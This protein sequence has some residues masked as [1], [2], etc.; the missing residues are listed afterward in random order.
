MAKPGSR[1]ARQI[2]RGERPRDAKVNISGL[3]RLATLVGEAHAEL[4]HAHLQRETNPWQ[5]AITAE[6]ARAKMETWCVEFPGE[7]AKVRCQVGMHPVTMDGS[8]ERGREAGYFQMPLRDGT[9][10]YFQRRTDDCLQAAIA[11]CLQIPPYLVPDLQIDQQRI[12]DKEPE[13]I[14]GAGWQAMG[15]WMH[16]NGVTIKVHPGPKTTSRRWIGV[17][18]SAYDSSTDHCLLMSGRDCLFDAASLV[19][20][21]KDEP[22]SMYEHADIDYAITIEQR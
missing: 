1:S 22:V 4:E 18:T 9:T 10:G 14:E 11:S 2:A 13:E 19:P 6:T 16:K 3:E 5:A 21:G 17:V 20:P 15:R 8:R 7:L 12:D